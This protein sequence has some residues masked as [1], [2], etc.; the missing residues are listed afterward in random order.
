[1]DYILLE[2][3]S[4]TGKVVRAVVGSNPYGRYSYQPVPGI[5]GEGPWWQIGALTVDR[6][7]RLFLAEWNPEDQASVTEL[8]ATAKPLGRWEL[9]GPSGRRGWPPQGIALDPRGNV[10]VADTLANRVLKLAFLTAR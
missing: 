5:S 8:S 9:P 10:Y 7:D 6:H 4:P 1:M 2:T 3:L